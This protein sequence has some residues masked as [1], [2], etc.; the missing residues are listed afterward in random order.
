[1]TDQTNTKQLLQ[2]IERALDGQFGSVMR[3]I[4]QRV[5]A[6]VASAAA[7]RTAR[8]AG[9]NHPHVYLPPVPDDYDVR[10]RLSKDHDLLLSHLS[11]GKTVAD[12]SYMSDVLLSMVENFVAWASYA[13]EAVQQDSEELVL[14]VPVSQLPEKLREP[15]TSPRLPTAHFKH[16]NAGLLSLHVADLLSPGRFFPRSSVETDRNMRQPIVYVAIVSDF[17]NYDDN[18]EDEDWH[19]L[20]YAR[21]MKTG[22]SR[23][24]GKLSIGVGGHINPCDTELRVDDMESCVRAAACRELREE[25]CFASPA[26]ET[27]VLREVVGEKGFTEPFIYCGS[28]T[29]VDSV[30]MGIFLTVHVPA[31]LARSISVRD[32]RS[33][34]VPLDDTNY[35][36]LES[37][38]QLFVA[39]LKELLF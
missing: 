6:S 13:P 17:N 16:E 23:L 35:D 19:V 34:W 36:R 2:T 14:A 39:E 37:W 9:H 1:M 38:S 21:P 10:M 22:E 28:K 4:S 27:A 11:S 33:A 20:Q 12:G 24:A 7:D 29:D 30:H 25:L 32:T 3:N 5:V 18:R 26:A 15:A 31:H 8:A